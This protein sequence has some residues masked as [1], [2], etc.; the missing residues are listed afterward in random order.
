MFL[1][2]L[3]LLLSSP[4]SIFSSTCNRFSCDTC[5][6]EFLLQFVLDSSVVGYSNFELAKKFTVN[7]IQALENINPN[8]SRLSYITFDNQIQTYYKF[9][10]NFTKHEFLSIIE[11]ITYNWNYASTDINLALKDALSKFQ[12][13][14]ISS[15]GSRVLIFMSDG[16][17]SQFDIQNAINLHN[18]GVKVF[19]IGVG[20]FDT[21]LLSSIA[22]P[23]ELTYA[24]SH[25]SDLSF[26]Q[27]A[28]IKSI[29]DEPTTT[30]ANIEIASRIVRWVPK[31]YEFNFEPKFNLQITVNSQAKVQLYASASTKT[32]WQGTN[33][34][35]IGSHNGY[36]NDGSEDKILRLQGNKSYNGKV[37]LTLISDS[38]GSFHLKADECCPA[39]CHEGSNEN[40]NI[41]IVDNMI[42]AEACQKSNFGLGVVVGLGIRLIVMVAIGGFV[43]WRKMQGKKEVYEVEKLKLKAVVEM[44]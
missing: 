17:D 29:C 7:I 5:P 9:S 44:S 4:S 41:K 31:Y 1:F 25:Y 33:S 37:Y 13:Y 30:T 23:P 20:S 42:I 2:P 43:M 22:S 27:D 10:S 28:F 38:N 8:N 14:P 36:T 24:A 18:I 34:S 16:L 40:N 19:A 32:P 15:G 21:Q 35:N 39:V 26:I 11:S 12:S 3:L 6:I